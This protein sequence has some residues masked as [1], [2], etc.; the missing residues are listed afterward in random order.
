MLQTKQD[1][2]PPEMLEYARTN[3]LISSVESNR[4]EKDPD[5]VLD[6]SMFMAAVDR[7][8]SAWDKEHNP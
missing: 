8:F 1:I 6:K 5:I 2:F 3:R 7:L 4:G